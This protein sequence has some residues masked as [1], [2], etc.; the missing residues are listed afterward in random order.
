MEFQHQL[1]PRLSVTMAYVH[2]QRYNNTVPTSTTASG[3]FINQYR[4]LDQ[5]TPMQFFNP[6]SG[7]PLPYQYYNL[8]SAGS[9]AQNAS[10]G[11]IA[12]VEPLH[13]TK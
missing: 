11:T 8:S 3:S 9:T 13:T 5:Y 2:W 4:K 1:L 12:M 6:I 10:G 7:E